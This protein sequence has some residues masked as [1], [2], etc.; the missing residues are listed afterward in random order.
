MS[1]DDW[2][3]NGWLVAHKT[4]KREI[5]DLLGVADR[6]LRDCQAQGLSADW[7]LNIAYNSALQSAKTALAAAGFRAARDSHHYRVFQSLEYTIGADVKLIDQCDAFRKKRNQGNY[8]VAGA[9]SDKEAKEMLQLATQL[10]RS[11]EDW[12]RLKHRKLMG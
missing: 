2:V 12:L 4:S 1:L 9:V 11:V 10:R 5:A 7:K 3:K 8:E 6:D